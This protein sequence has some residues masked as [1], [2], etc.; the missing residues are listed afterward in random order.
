MYESIVTFDLETGTKTANKRKATKWHPDNYVVAAGWKYGDQ[1]CFGSYYEERSDVEIPDLTNATLLVGLNIKFDLLWLWEHPDIQAFL[2]RGGKI[3]DVQYTEYLMQGQ[4]EWAHMLSMNEM[5]QAYGGTLKLDAVKEMWEAGI[6][7]PDIPE[8]LLMKY[9]LG[10]P[11]EEIQG[12]VNNTWLIFMGQI[13]KL[14]KFPPN[15]KNMV[16]NRMDGLLATTEIEHNGLYVDKEL[17]MEIR[18]EVAAKLANYT[19]ELEQYLPKL[20]PELEFNWGSN[21][22]RSFMIYGG[23]ASYDKWVQHRDEETGELLYANKTEKWPLIYGRPYPPRTCAEIIASGEFGSELADICDTFKSGKRK[24]E[25][26]TKNV[27]VPDPEKPKG[28]KQPHYF[29]FPRI[30]EPKEAWASTLLDGVGKPIYSTSADVITELSTRNI[31]FLKA[32]AAR[33]KLKKDLGTYYWEEDKKGVRKGM[34]TLINDQDG[35][36]HPNYNHTSTVT[37]RL[38]SSNPN[39]QNIPRKDSSDVKKVFKSRFGDDGI[40]CEIDYSSLEVVI[41]AVLTND[42]QLIKDLNAG[43]D[44]HCKRLAAKL[45]REYADIKALHDAGDT[46]ISLQRTGVKEFTFQR[47]YGAGAIAIAA[48]TGMTVEEVK[49]LMSVEEIMY[50]GIAEFDKQLEKAIAKS[51]RP[52]TQE[53]YVEKRRIILGIGEWFSP[54]G[55]RFVWKE[56]IT[57]EFLWKHGKYTGFSPTERKNYPPQGIGGEVV[58]TMLGLVFRWFLQNNR[59]DGKAMMVNT[60]HD[61]L[62]LDLHKSVADKVIPTVKRIMEA[63]PTKYKRD[64]NMDIPVPFPTE[65][66]TGPSMYHVSHYKEGMYGQSI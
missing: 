10:C 53:V 65:A 56:Q 58:Q 12:D 6:D 32:L 48:S 27:T 64:F 13:K 66:E 30:T 22:H 63:V 55:T 8:D 29:K 25:V 52:T 41:Q 42:P 49:E 62:Y 36:I 43:I 51:R 1:P 19:A 21:H 33:Q 23:V 28:A 15:F 24:G 47:A 17:G 20:P 34:L 2:K 54:T 16:A 4:Q 39:L 38:S 60:V 18:E 37:G 50:A 7:T 40:I 35:C 57:P 61:S 45:H 59:F 46:D 31:P 14:N 3:W 44:M 5:V 26:K 11:E 9:L